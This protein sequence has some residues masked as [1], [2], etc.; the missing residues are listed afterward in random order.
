MTT[1]M[2][3]R[4]RLWEGGLG[5]SCSVLVTCVQSFVQIVDDDFRA[6]A[7][8]ACNTLLLLGDALELLQKILLAGVRRVFQNRVQLN[9]RYLKEP[10]VSASIAIVVSALPRL[11][12]NA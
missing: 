6:R 3:T 12:R 9:V 5:G 8:R 4:V 1:Q 10:L 7:D 2:S 11:Q